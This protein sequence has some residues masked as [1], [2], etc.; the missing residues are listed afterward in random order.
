MHKSAWYIQGWLVQV[1]WTPTTPT[2]LPWP[3]T[4]KGVQMYH[5]Y[6]HAKLW[7]CLHALH[8]SWGYKLLIGYVCNDLGHLCTPAYQTFSFTKPL[9]FTRLTQSV[10]T[11]H[12]LARVTLETRPCTETRVT[13]S[14]S[15]LAC[16][17]N[18]SL[19]IVSGCAA[20]HSHAYEWSCKATCQNF[21]N[22]YITENWLTV[23]K[24]YVG[25][26]FVLKRNKLHPLVCFLWV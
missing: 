19:Y 24:L 1:I 9:I 25:M 7:T 26:I 10:H 12:T 15:V 23:I 6:V 18:T 2:P 4:T 11:L 20:M 3:H 8:L 5:L 13:V 22:F 14:F 17:L 16:S 21:K